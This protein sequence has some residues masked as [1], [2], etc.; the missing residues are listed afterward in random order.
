MASHSN[1]PCSP[2]R[3]ASYITGIS[4]LANPKT[5]TCHQSTEIRSSAMGQK[6]ASLK[7]LIKFF[8]RIPLSDFL[9]PVSMTRGVDSIDVALEANTIVWLVYEGDAA[10]L[11]TD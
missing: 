10:Q 3:A 6:K 8:K 11:W 9:F 1:S 5:A 2:M 4:K 7:A